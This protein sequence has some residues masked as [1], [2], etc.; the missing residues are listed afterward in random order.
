MALWVMDLTACLHPIK[1]RVKT[2]SRQATP[3]PKDPQVYPHEGDRLTGMDRSDEV[4]SIL[5]MGLT[6][7]HNPKE[8]SDSVYYL[9]F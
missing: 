6:F 7:I 8:G 5:P 3:Y 9:K 2:V 1:G 4:A